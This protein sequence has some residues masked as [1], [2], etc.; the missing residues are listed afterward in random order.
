MVGSRLSIKP[1]L[2]RSQCRGRG[3]AWK[4]VHRLLSE[5]TSVPDHVAATVVPQLEADK[6]YS[7]GKHP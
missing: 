1:A 4:Y 7:P 3:R 5:V 6:Q 2:K